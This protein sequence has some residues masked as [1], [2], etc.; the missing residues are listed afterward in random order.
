MSCE[1]DAED[2][3]EEREKGDDEGRGAPGDGDAPEGWAVRREYR[4]T[5]RDTL[6]ES[7]TLLRGR[8]WRPGAGGPSD[9]VR[10][11]LEHVLEHREPLVALPVG[12]LTGHDGH[13]GVLGERIPAERLAVD[14]VFVVRPGEKIATDGVIESGT[15][16][17]DTSLLTGESVPVDAGPGDDQVFGGP[18]ADDVDG[19]IVNIPF[20][21][22]YADA[23]ALVTGFVRA[24]RPEVAV[25]SST[26]AIG[27]SPTRGIK[28]APTGSVY[29][30]TRKPLVKSA[31]T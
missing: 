23:K 3:G 13:P 10:V 8:M 31:R 19:G 25:P 14:D 29:R 24:A 9:E 22:Q 20:I 18:N 26:R 27:P 28:L 5:Y 15:S 6:V 7:E 4:S 30:R 12:R 17:V 16:S 2:E 1:A 11:G 21:R